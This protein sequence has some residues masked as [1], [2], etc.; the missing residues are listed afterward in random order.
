MSERMPWQE[1][2]SVS[3]P[4]KLEGKFIQRVKKDSF[5]E[6]REMPEIKHYKNIRGGEDE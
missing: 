5:S 3:L 2:I 6:H 1:T 4:E